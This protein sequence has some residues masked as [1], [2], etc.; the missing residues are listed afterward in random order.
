[1]NT[2]KKLILFDIDGTLIHS[3]GAGVRALNRAFSELFGL[4]QAFENITMA[5]KTDKEIMK[6]GLEAHGFPAAD[7]NLSSM[8]KGYL[9]FLKDEI[10]N[11][12]R[13]VKPGIKEAL[14]LLSQKKM[15]LG[16]LTGNLEM[17]AKIKLGAFGLYEYFLDGAFGSDHEDRNKLLPIAIEKFSKRGFDF[18]PGECVIVGDTPRDVTCAK[19]HDACCI[20]VAT[21][22]YTREDLLNTKADIVFDSLEETEQCMDFIMN[23]S[24]H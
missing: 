21:G 1:M 12:W 23:C 24:P 16:L 20:A 3:G 4:E 11:P 6:E 19:I 2:T 10:D 18:S 9:H 7:G 15:T 14:T 17:G 8:I 5:G 13:R 22:P